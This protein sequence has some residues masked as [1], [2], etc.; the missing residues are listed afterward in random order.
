MRKLMI[1]FAFISFLGIN[2][3]FA[4]NQIRGTVTDFESGMGIP[5][6]QIIVKA[7]NLGTVTDLDGNYI[8]NNVP[9]S[10]KQLEFRFVGMETELID[11]DGRNVI[12]V[13][14]KSTTQAIEGVVVTALGIS[15]EKKS[16]GYASQGVDKDELMRGN[17]INPISSLSGK[18]AGLNISGQ[19]FSGSQNI[20]IRGASSFSSNN[21][22]LFVVDGIPISNENFNTV[23][24]QA[25][26]GGYDYGSMTN[27]LSSYDVES[28]EVL[29]GSAASALYGSRGQNGVIMITTK[30]GK[31]GKDSFAVEFNS[32]VTFES[33][34]ILP[35]L[36]R[37]YGGGLGLRS[38]EYAGG[39]Y[40]IPNYNVDE[41]WGPRYDPNK[42]VLH[43]WGVYDYENGITSKPVTAPWV[44]PKKDVADFYETGVSY[45][46][47]I[48]VINTTENTSLRVGYTNLNMTGIVPNSSQQ[49]HSLNLNGSAGLF[50]NLIRVNS[51]INYINSY[52]KGR[53]QFGYGD[54]SQS[55]KFFQ[56][57]QR[58]LDFEKLKDYKNPDGTMRTWNRK[59]L[60]NP[61]AAYADNPYWT[62]YKNY[63]DDDRNRLYGKVGMDVKLTDYL[64]ASG[65]FYLDRFAF[66]QRERVSKG[67]QATP[68]FQLIQR[69]ALETNLEGKLN[70]KK[71]FND[72]SI[73]AMLGGNTRNN[74]YSRFQ[75]NTSGGLVI[76]DLFNLNNSVNPATNDQYVREKRVNSWFGSASIGY[77]YFAY[78]DFTYRKDYDSSLPEDNN[79]YGYFSVQTSLILSELFKYDWL[80]N[81]K[82]RANYGQT[83]NG[84]DP[85]QVYNT[86]IFGEPFGGTPQFYNS[87]RLN[88]KGL[89]PEFTNEV[90]VGLEGVFL[91]NRVG[92]DISLY[93]KVTEN[94]IVP[95]E[96]TGASGYLQQVINAGK[97]NN[98][99]IELL[100]YGTPVKTNNFAWDINLNFA[101][102]KNTV[103]ELP[104][105]VDKLQI[106]RAA[107]G[108]AFIN[109]VDGAT[110][111]ELYAY[112]YLYD[113]AGNKVINPRT[114]FYMRG[115]LH[116]MGSVLP[117]YTMGIRN[118]L[119]YKGFDIS[120]L[121][122]ISKGGVYY[123]LT[124]MWG[125]Y[126]GM[127]EETVMPTTGNNTIREDGMVL[128]GVLAD[129]SVDDEGNFVVENT[130]PNNI[131]ISGFDFSES[132]Y[133]SAVHPSATSVF[134]ASYI[135]LREVALGYTFPKLIDFVKSVRLSVYGRNLFTWGLDNTGIDP[136][137]VVGGAGNIQGLEG[138]IIPATRS[139]GFNL[140]LN[141]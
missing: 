110:F 71:N 85:Y 31:K 14:M 27:D 26:Y 22:P 139:F 29:K 10:A 62:A 96:V 115:D 35:N 133:H 49:K 37:E 73:L 15:R 116:S 123:S 21:Q 130:R 83:G 12:N 9:A 28:V 101:K 137:T 8:L 50:D 90:E 75:G 124:N 48:G 40:L 138:G 25:G 63:Q 134:D 74:D 127:M 20:L 109:S 106:Q 1:F 118:A 105:G 47:A 97:I 140:Q 43:W 11:I 13:A 129:V 72:F 91:K 39:K 67:S 66:N 84:T 95:I 55:Q 79:S 41:S 18:V 58:Q 92:F 2:A 38:V 107:F 23:S 56:W 52:T 7:T 121:I 125:M 108:G 6:V 30:K 46:N 114:G 89:K 61:I 68:G 136:E 111:Q 88:N 131:A 65:N 120:A 81:L 117:D 57:G 82:L 5:G 122:D 86:W 70:F 17:D 102:N 59:S 99:G 36:Q 34:S 51:S 132:F 3:T 4:Q 104:D 126:S 69:Q 113:D 33:L 77:K 141:F 103:M 19:N 42:Q 87:I 93:D 54:N 94:Q 45:Q 100:L 32:G 128:D 53:P 78:L 80:D 112:D 44:A 16:L 64:T 24:A 76:D 135:K 119:K 98:R 60:T